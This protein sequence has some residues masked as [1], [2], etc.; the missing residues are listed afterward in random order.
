[1]EEIHFKLSEN[2]LF[3]AY[4]MWILKKQLRWEAY[5][6]V[7]T[8]AVLC[9]LNWD[10]RIAVAFIGLSLYSFIMLLYSVFVIQY[11]TRQH[12]R[13]LPQT[14]AG[15]TMRFEA[16]VLQNESVLGS[17][18]L[19]WLYEVIPGKEVIL[20]SLGPKVFVPVPV[21]AF[22]DAAQMERFVAVTRGLVEKRSLSE[23]GAISHP[24]E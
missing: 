12:L 5:I 4:R 23:S 10:N 1:M 19:N 8:V 20:L 3:A 14:Y 7:A 15:N 13:A 6:G 18:Q 17:A 21:R 2:D 22:K 9:I 11:S 16:G 24:V